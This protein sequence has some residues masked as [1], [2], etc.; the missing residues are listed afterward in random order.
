[1]II[2]PKKFHTDLMKLSATL[3]PSNFCNHSR[4]CFRDVSADV[5]SVGFGIAFGCHVSLISFN[6][7]QFS[8]LSV[9]DDT[10][11]LEVF[12]RTQGE[13]ILLHNPLFAWDD[14]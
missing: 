1:M 6:G 2:S 10:G 12:Y 9:L 5:L 7:K 13:G 14:P 11:A 4:M 3:T 8:C